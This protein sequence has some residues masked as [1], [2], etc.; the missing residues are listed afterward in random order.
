[1]NKAIRVPI[2][3]PKNNEK[4]R[5][6]PFVPSKTMRKATGCQ[7]V[8]FY[9]FLHCRRRQLESRR[10]HP[11][12]MRRRSN[13]RLRV[14]PSASPLTPAP[15]TPAR[16]GI[17]GFPLLPSLPVL[18]I[19]LLLMSSCHDQ[20]PMIELLQPDPIYLLL[21]L[22]QRPCVRDEESA[23]EVDD[24]GL[25]SEAGD[26][27]CWR[28]RG[29]GGKAWRCRCQGDTDGSGDARDGACCFRR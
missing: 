17:R 4:A 14:P 23:A 2:V 26:A 20:A 15:T 12:C 16:S 28:R 8:C 21:V 27:E 9:G 25:L 22:L 24:P 3:P 11:G 7:H 10:A 6:L 1:M 18:P 29:A 5:Q 13:R 19:G